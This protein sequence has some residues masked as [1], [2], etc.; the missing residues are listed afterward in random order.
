MAVTPDRPGGEG[1]VLP[2]ATIVPSSLRAIVW[3]RPAAMAVTP[4]SPAGMLSWPCEFRPH[5]TTV[6]LSLSATV[7]KRPAAM[8]VTPD[9]PVGISVCP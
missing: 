8:A 9:S 1:E 6:P 3:Y 2:H 7:W 4:E 5:A